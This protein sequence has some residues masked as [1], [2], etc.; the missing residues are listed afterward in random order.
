MTVGRG[1]FDMRF[2]TLYVAWLGLM[3]SDSLS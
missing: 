2:I 1:G 3:V